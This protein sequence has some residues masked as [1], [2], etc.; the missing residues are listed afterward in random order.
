VIGSVLIW[1]KFV[2]LKAE[3]RPRLTRQIPRL[4]KATR[5][6]RIMGH[7]G[8]GQRTTVRSGFRG[9][10]SD[11]ISASERGQEGQRLIAGSKLGHVG[12]ASGQYLQC[13]FIA[14]SACGCRSQEAVRATGPENSPDSIMI[15]SLPIQKT[16]P[17][18]G[19]KI[20]SDCS[21]SKCPATKSRTATVR[22]YPT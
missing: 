4:A 11:I 17:E 21:S 14:K 9:F 5:S 15:F 7:V 1:S 22:T 16:G 3:T 12:F 2:P 8:S 10:R 19:V 13:I 18:N 6:C 20:M